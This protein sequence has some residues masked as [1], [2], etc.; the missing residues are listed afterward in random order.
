MSESIT[1]DETVQFSLRPAQPD[2]EPFLSE[3]YS[4]TRNEEVSAFGWNAAQKEMFLKLQFTAQRQHYQMAYP[5]AEDR[6]ILL[7][8]RPAGR[9]LVS[10]AEQEIL[11]VDIALLPEHRGRGIGAALIRELTYEVAAKGAPVRLHVEKHNRAARLYDRLGFTVIGDTGVYY[12]MEKRSGN[13]K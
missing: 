3:L 12:E 8:D 6:I 7:E 4:S 11:L 2:D 9:I 10:R 13:T 5:D 1:K